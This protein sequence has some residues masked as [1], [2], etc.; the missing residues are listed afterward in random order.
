MGQRRVMIQQVERS[1]SL[2][3]G[4][5]TAVPVGQCPGNRCGDLRGGGVGAHM[6]GAG[7]HMLVWWLSAAP[8]LFATI[9]FNLS[10]CKVL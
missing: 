6:D 10:S 9:F 5:H 3:T 1:L 4:R 7:I 8:H 2:P